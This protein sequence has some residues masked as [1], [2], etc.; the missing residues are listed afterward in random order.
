VARSTVLVKSPNMG[1]HEAVG[2]RLTSIHRVGRMDVD[3][4]ERLVLTLRTA[5]MYGCIERAVGESWNVA[6]PGG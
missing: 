5:A 3:E 1:N 2:K 6:P 4:D